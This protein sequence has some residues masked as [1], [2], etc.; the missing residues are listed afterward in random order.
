MENIENVKTGDHIICFDDYSHDYV[1]HELIVN[2]I[3][4]DDEEGVVLYGTDLT[5]PEDECDDYIT[6]VNKVNFVCIL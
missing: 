4:Y 6:R 5:Y 2:H 3:E 1:E